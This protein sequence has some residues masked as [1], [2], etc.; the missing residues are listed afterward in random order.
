MKF[1]SQYLIGLFLFLRMLQLSMDRALGGDWK[2]L[3]VFFAGQPSPNDVL[4]SMSKRCG[5]D[6]TSG[7]ESSVELP[8]KSRGT[9]LS[10]NREEIKY[11]SW[12]LLIASELLQRRDGLPSKGEIAEFRLNLAYAE[13]L[14]Q[15][16]LKRT[17]RPIE[18]IEHFNQ[19]E[20]ANFHSIEDLVGKSWP[21]G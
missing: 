2:E 12:C 5:Y 1:E 15:R 18:Y 20:M 4:R 9:K 6:V 21:S 13:E 19:N 11:I 16:R 14:V 17:T 3:C 7:L 10:L 8:P